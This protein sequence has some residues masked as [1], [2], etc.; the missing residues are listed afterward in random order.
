MIRFVVS[1]LALIAI[2]GG[3]CDGA[4]PVLS[5]H[6]DHL[7]AGAL[8]DCDAYLDKPDAPPLQQRTCLVLANPLRPNLRVFDMSEGRFLLAPIGYAPL[9]VRIDGMT[10]QLVS[11][12]DPTS[13]FVFGLDANARQ[14][15]AINARNR[16]IV[17]SFS[18]AATSERLSLLRLPQKIFSVARGVFGDPRVLVT[19]S[20]G[21]MQLNVF[22]EPAL[23][24]SLGTTTAGL[25]T[26][27]DSAYDP[28]SGLVARLVSNGTNSI[29]IA[30]ATG[31]VLVNF[32]D[33]PDVGA[34]KVALGTMI[35]EGVEAPHLLIMKQNE[36]KL[37]VLRLNMSDSSIALDKTLS[38]SK[39]ATQAYFPGTG[40]EVLGL[41]GGDKNWISVGTDDGLIYF[42]TSANIVGPE[43][44]SPRYLTLD[45]GQ[46]A[47][48]MNGRGLVQIL[49]G[50]VKVLTGEQALKDRV[51][52][53]RQLL[54][55]FASGSVVGT[56]E[57]SLSGTS[58]LIS[59]NAG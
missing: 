50:G 7:S 35:T 48:A 55:L 43:P 44:E 59:R 5:P 18:A 12:N 46:I 38:L 34:A 29:V 30:N 49:G 20:D 19:Y 6:L 14:L 13:G 10:T 21:S 4:P 31:Q 17:P 24:W 23:T 8:L 27:I 52:C 56:C 25:G 28:V 22:N 9:G 16:S 53:P 1:L 40:P 45:S 11:L 51:V 42:L 57:G 41:Q 26:V 36:A 33:I 47:G 32:A 2:S 37:R 15:F 58:L 54:F 39:S 3:S